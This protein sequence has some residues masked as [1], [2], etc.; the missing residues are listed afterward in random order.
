[1]SQVTLQDL[2]RVADSLTQLKGRSVLDASIRSDFRQLK[3][4]LSDGLIL[5]VA[6]EADEA[7]RPHLEVDLVRQPEDRSRQLEV[8]FEEI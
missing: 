3:L 4:D 5:V 8:G 1:M 6:L 7:G 2:R